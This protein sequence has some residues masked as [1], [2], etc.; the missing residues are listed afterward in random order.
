MLLE[1]ER[2]KDLSGKPVAIIVHH[3]D[4]NAPLPDKV[5][6]TIQPDETL[7][8]FRGG[9]HHKLNHRDR[10]RYYDPDEM[11]NLDLLLSVTDV[12]FRFGP[13]LQ[14][15]FIAAPHPE[16]KVSTPAPGHTVVIRGTRRYDVFAG[17]DFRSA[18]T[19]LE[20]HEQKSSAQN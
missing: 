2:P 16:T 14:P 20:A 11:A 4:T 3:P 6:H 10:D 15:E 5:H 1:E 7:F 9:Y 12:M 17:V 8:F 13:E 19:F 18:M